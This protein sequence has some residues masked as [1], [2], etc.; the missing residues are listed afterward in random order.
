MRKYI[1]SDI[2]PKWQKKW[3]DDKLYQVDLSD[4]AK[5]FYILIE[6]SY[7]SGDLHMG[8]WFA[9]AVPDILARFKR[10]QGLNV[11]FPN[12][13]DAF[14]LPAEN[15]AIKKG[16]H[17]KD[18]TLGNIEKMKQQFSTMGA[19][20]N[21]EQEVITCLPEYYK[22]NQWIFLKMLERGIAY[23]GKALANWCPNCQ[24]VL[25]NE[26]VEAGKCWRCGSEVI[27]K[28]VEQWF[29][30]LTE[31]ADK[32]LWENPLSRDLSNG[33]D[34]PIPVKVGQNNWIGKSEGMEI[35]FKVVLDKLEQK[36][37]S[38]EVEKNIT[39]YTVFPETIFGV[40]YMVLAPEH[41]LVEKL[42]TKEQ[43]SEVKQYLETTKK[44]TQLERTSL[45]K[46][47]TGVFTGSY[48]IN[49][50]NEKKFPIWIADYVIGGYGTGAVMGV[51]GSDHR[52]FAFAKKYDL[53]VIRVIG[54]STD[55]V[56]TVEN[57]SDVLEEGILVNSEQFNGLH[58][59]DPARDKIKDWME[60]KGF[61]KRKQQYHIHDWSV[62]RQRYWGTPIPVI[63]C[64]IDGVVPVPEKDLPVELPY[65][66][67]YAPQGKPPLATAED[68]V[69]VACPECGKPARREVET[70]DTFFDSSW[71]FLRY[72]DPKN[73][74]EI[75]SKKV[76]QDW[77]PLDIY[78]GGAEHTLGHTLYSR[79]F[80]K[81]LIDIGVISF[82][83]TSS[84]GLRRASE[85]AKKR[86]NR[87][88]ILGPDGQKMS[89]SR[90][91]VVNP[92]DQVKDYGADAVRLYLA[93]IGP[94]AETVAPWDSQG[95]NGV[96]HFLQRV[97]T[98]SEKV[99]GDRVQ[100]TA[101]LRMMHK[102]IK[103]V[104]EDIEGSKFN[105]AVAGM[106]EY[107]NYLSRKETISKEEYKTFL[108]LLAP[109][110]PHMT[111]EL[112]NIV[113]RD[114]SIVKNEKRK[115]KNEKSWSIHKQSWPVFDNKYLEEDEVIIVVQ[116]NGKVRD[117]FVIGKDL[118]NNK[119]VVEKMAKESEKVQ[120]FLIGK[121][122]KKTVYI[123]GKIISVVV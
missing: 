11:F 76:V 44:K 21:W 14:G 103:R 77:M 95:L 123:P 80:Y 7:P 24:T 100:G 75:F 18:W 81:F 49:P 26:N 105:T 67:D 60:E 72:L 62:S 74:K 71:Y 25:A 58:T 99:T 1:P 30:K 16:V 3:L 96:Y 33:V 85:Y 36:S 53:E 27:Q 91:N 90:G 78:F 110:A 107:I 114:S 52:D 39:V 54:K 32:L 102:T 83:P 118:V 119:D 50:V 112:W 48:G 34:W 38:T 41:S 23:K 121:T 84:S 94:Y 42:T 98:L 109:F 101:D 57:E 56:S 65:E 59:P 82:D 20:F 122:V 37:S 29:L 106:M 64:D 9:F 68:W 104:T 117:N 61:G 111:E 17:P 92:D 6:F 113:I 55:D 35:S 89:K 2:E 10:M 120:K 86:V 8:H 97:W 73:D 69:R 87:G 31:Y 15:A 116:V 4:A 66:V 45:E 22:W 40:T 19:S 108:L 28:E 79:F 46:E 5:R 115:T 88:L 47:K 70:M 12:G 63:Y 13:F 43:E 51:P 93:F